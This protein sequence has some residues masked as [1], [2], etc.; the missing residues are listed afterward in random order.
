MIIERSLPLLKIAAAVGAAA[1]GVWL[2]KKAKA[3]RRAP[4][5]PE[6]EPRVERFDERRPYDVPWGVEWG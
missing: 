1:L 4:K 6:Y 3:R 5:Q 2:V